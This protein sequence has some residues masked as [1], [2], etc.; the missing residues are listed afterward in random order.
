MGAFQTL[1]ASDFCLVFFVRK[2]L[3]KGVF[4]T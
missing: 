1:L 2:K 3:P 4:A